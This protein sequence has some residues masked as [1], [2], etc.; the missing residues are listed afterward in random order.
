MGKIVK[1]THKQYLA[2][3]ALSNSGIKYLLPPSCPA[4]FRAWK[5]GHQKDTD[6]LKFGRMFHAMLLEPEKFSQDYAICDAPGNTKAGKEQ[7]ATALQ[8]NKEPIKVADF[9]KA[10]GMSGAL[11]NNPV[12][13]MF[14][15]RAEQKEMSAYWEISR[16][17]IDVQCKARA[18]LI[19]VSIPKHGKILVDAKSTDDASYQAVQKHI[20]DYGYYRQAAWYLEGFKR[21]GEDVNTFALAFVEKEP[22]YLTR[23]GILPDA[24]I[25]KGREE[26][27]QAIGIY[28]DCIRD[29]Y[30]PGYSKDLQIFDLPE[31]AYRR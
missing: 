13:E 24:A 18:D 16:G 28:C 19:T 5:D 15:S 25:D 30:W 20:Y 4:K 1:D 12:F 2:V 14:F 21:C 10:L 23:V 27:S 11:H 26:C 9:D 6:A 31:W 3:D 7:R 8:E 22:P 29:G 17:D